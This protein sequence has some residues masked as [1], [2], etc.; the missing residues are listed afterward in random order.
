MTIPELKKTITQEA[1]DR[2]ARASGDLN[3]IHIDEAFAKQTLAGG[4]I[5][6]GMLVL[7]YVSQ[8]MTQAY[9]RAWLTGGRLDVRFRNPARPGDTLTLTGRVRQ[10]TAAGDGTA[11]VCE[12][13]CKN[14]KGEP[15]VTGD[16]T[17]RL[18][19]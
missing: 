17:V 2:Y 14:Q 3:P 1:I 4:T 10:E 18:K 6:H 15:I 13:I 9:G 8:M 11:V 19:R 12:V 5:A 7:A 16:A